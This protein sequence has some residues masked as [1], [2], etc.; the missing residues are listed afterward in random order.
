MKKVLK[1]FMAVIAVV[2]MF[3]TILSLNFQHA[4]AADDSVVITFKS[5][6]LYDYMVKELTDSEGIYSVDDDKLI[7]DAK[8]TAVD[9]VTRISIEYYDSEKIT[10]DLTGLEYFKNCT[11][12]YVS[13]GRYID[14]KNDV[15]T[16]P[17]LTPVTKL[18]KL[19]ALSINQVIVEKVSSLQ[20][21]KELK[22]L[23]FEGISNL[24]ASV[25]SGMTSLKT[26]H[27][28]S[29]DLDDED[30]KAIGTL[31]SLETLYLGGFNKEGNN[32]SNITPL[33]NLTNL[34]VLY[35]SNNKISDISPLKGLTKM[36]SLSLR[37]NQ[38][39][40]LSPL[41]G[42]TSLHGLELGRDKYAGSREGNP[43]TSME[44]IANL[45]I[46]T[47]KAS[48]CNIKDISFINKMTDLRKL[49]LSGNAIED[50]SPLEG[51]EFSSGLQIYG[52]K[53]TTEAVA[54][55][56]VVL[57]EA[58]SRALD[59]TFIGYDETASYSCSG[60]QISS[61]CKTITINQNATSASITVANYYSCKAVGRSTLTVNVEPIIVEFSSDCSN[62]NVGDS[63]K[64][65]AKVRSGYGGIK[66]SFL[67][68][69]KDTGAW[70]RFNKDFVTDNTMVWTA[71][72]AED[73][74]F[75]VEAK[76]SKGNIAR[77]D[78]ILIT[79]NEREKLSV[80]VIASDSNVYVG[81]T[82][83]LTA[84]AVGGS[85]SYTYKYKIHN[86]FT[87]EWYT[88]NNNYIN[89]NTF[90]W[91]AGSAGLRE[92]YVEVKDSKGKVA[93]SRGYSVYVNTVPTLAVYGTASDNIINVGDKLT[94]TGNASGGIGNY[95]YSY[96][97]YNPASKVWYRFNKEFVT[98]N[99]FTW[100]AGSSGARVFYVEVKDSRGTV[101]RSNG[102]DV[103][104]K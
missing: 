63:V 19:K 44:P 90:M 77:S 52:Q 67:V 69:N 103:T 20:G 101:K 45:P 95:T 65:T 70:Y 84:N 16:I 24:D 60:C 38:I 2:M 5:K 64:F 55:E 75:Y 17:D 37:C 31:T 35:L 86:F 61:D 6:L 98:S 76:D 48:C 34:T 1:K 87:N 51:R 46:T 91:K 3:V 41:S 25:I 32:I 47:L 49:D 79:V 81:D 23:I 59:P 4:E 85:E 72:T 71:K 50:F 39:K 11:S 89:S 58:I 68:Y 29:C 97:I 56:T 43:I 42:M 96:L 99:N 83:K 102:I 22:S 8:Q 14:G 15:V 92:F 27:L 94:I 7:I 54:G 80:N 100:K 18:T 57:P 10:L 12:F 36:T 88:F 62:I 78:S 28:T 104:V 82:V 21:L 30:V 66:Y 26:L 40:D 73:R 13:A 9:N 33:K 74:I 93:T 53:Y